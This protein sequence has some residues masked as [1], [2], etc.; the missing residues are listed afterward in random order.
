MIIAREDVFLSEEQS[1]CDLPDSRMS[2][3]RRGEEWG[4]LSEGLASAYKSAL[5]K[6][7]GRIRHR[8]LSASASPASEERFVALESACDRGNTRSCIDV[9][10]FR[11]AS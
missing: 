5:Q 8:I 9:F 6:H 1:L 2:H 3:R 4:D 10:S 7:H 11:Q